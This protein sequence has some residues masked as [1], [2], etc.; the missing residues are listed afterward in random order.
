RVLVGINGLDDDRDH[1]GRLFLAL[2]VV[3]GSFSF[4]RLVG[5]NAMRQKSAAQAQE[6]EDQQYGRR[7]FQFAERHGLNHSFGQDQD[8]RGY[9]HQGEGGFGGRGGQRAR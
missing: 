6:N 5:E 4:G 3:L 1:W 8:L 2:L 7:K 9:R